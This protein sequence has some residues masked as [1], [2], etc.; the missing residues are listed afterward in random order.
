M[1]PNLYHA[2]LAVAGILVS[3]GFTFWAGSRLL[4]FGQGPERDQKSGKAH[5]SSRV[6]AS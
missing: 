5:H 4:R 2:M 6:A 1:D 3:G